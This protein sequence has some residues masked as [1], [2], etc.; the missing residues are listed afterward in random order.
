M[1]AIPEYIS[2]AYWEGFFYNLIKVSLVA[3]SCY[4]KYQG[5]AMIDHKTAL[6]F[7]MTSCDALIFGGLKVV[8]FSS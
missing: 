4:L 5:L 7:V 2:F 8:I 1:I 3:N 6:R